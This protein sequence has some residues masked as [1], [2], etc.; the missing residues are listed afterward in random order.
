MQRLVIVTDDQN[1]QVDLL[2]KITAYKESLPHRLAR[3][4]IINERH[5]V[6][7]QH[8]SPTVAHWP[9]M[10]DSSVAGVVEADETYW[11]ALQREA[12][13]E[14]HLELEPL[15]PVATY[16][17]ETYHPGYGTWLPRFEGLFVLHVQLP[18]SVKADGREVASLEWMPL[19]DLKR[20]AET[21]PDKLT[22]GF[23]AALSKV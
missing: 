6:L 22:A 14:I 21:Q 7:V 3:L 17:T 10:L 13:E 20:R 2:D 12:R 23:I 15:E 4:L 9:N 11:D 1:Q 16:H 8:R 18:L 5:E 19:S